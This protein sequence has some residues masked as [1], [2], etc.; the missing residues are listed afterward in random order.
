[1]QSESK[2]LPDFS[3]I[4]I[5]SKAQGFN[6]TKK[7]IRNFPKAKIIEISDYKSIFNRP[8][9]DFQTQK[10]SM[11]LIL[12]I[13]K[14]PYIYKGTDILQDGGYK[15]FY[16]N[17]PMLNCLYNCSYCFLQGM[18]SSANI[19][20]FVNE[21][22]MQDAVKNE[23]VKRVHKEQPL[24]LSISYNTD[25]MA[26][27]NILPITKNWIQFAKLN[28]DLN[29][30]IRTKSGLYHSIKDIESSDQIVL[31]WTLSPD[32]VVR[33]YE[34]NTPP[35]SKRISAIKLALKDGWKVRL[36]FDPILYY[37]NWENDYLEL[38]NKVKSSLNLNQVLDI[39]VGTF[40]MSNDYFNR[41]RK[42]KPNSG[43]FY[44]NYKNENGIVSIDSKKKNSIFK[45]V[46][47][48]FSNYLPQNKIHYSI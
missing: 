28:L 34:L 25:L 8:R 24:M 27:E 1:M 38:F 10:Q 36:C 12:A 20:V 44:Q 26:F 29:L 14:P 16:Y 17:T 7:C 32:K 33:K 11:K 30:E 23:I 18:Y 9:Q 37:N 13:K 45:L 35:L 39:T 22:D 43:L 31:A 47:D 19:V 42:S 4:Y 40:R 48:N 41:I 5:E 15:N 3:H 2:F 21:I 46:S 6:L